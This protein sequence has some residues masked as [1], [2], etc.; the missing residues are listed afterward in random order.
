MSN[1]YTPDALLQAILKLEIRVASLEAAQ[2]TQLAAQFDAR[3]AEIE[4]RAVHI[5]NSIKASSV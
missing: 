4:A 1:L 5:R 2:L 3:A